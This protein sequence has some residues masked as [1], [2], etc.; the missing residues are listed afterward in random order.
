MSKETKKSKV[1]HAGRD[2]SGFTSSHHMAA[3]A[4]IRKM[5]DFMRK[6]KIMKDQVLGDIQS[7]A[8]NT[9]ES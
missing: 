7:I 1:T 3:E 4:T 6:Q 2:K 5:R 8:I 9:E